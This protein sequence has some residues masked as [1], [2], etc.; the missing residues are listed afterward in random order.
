MPQVKFSPLSQTARTSRLA[1]SRPYLKETDIMGD[2]E[3]TVFLPI[4]L[5]RSDSS[6]KR[7][8]NMKADFQ[9]F[10]N[11]VKRPVLS[12]LTAPVFLHLFVFGLYSMGFFLLADWPT[13]TGK[14]APGVLYSKGSSAW[15]I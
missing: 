6:E 9:E 1:A 2:E 10:E 15:C 8:E 3:A 11:R 5:E 13:R 4:G 12:W 7:Q 14:H